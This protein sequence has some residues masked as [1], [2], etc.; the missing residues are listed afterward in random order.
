VVPEEELSVED[1]ERLVK[2]LKKYDSEKKYSKEMDKELEG[3]ALKLLSLGEAAVPGLIEV[4]EDDEGLGVL[5]AMEA[6]GKI[7]DERAIAPLVD[8][9]ENPD[10]G[11]SAADSLLGFGPACV[12]EVIR[13][14]EHLIACPVEDKG[15]F[16][17]LTTYHLRTIGD[18]RCDRSIEFLNGLLDDYMSK[19]PRETFDPSKLDWKY[20]NVDFFQILDAMVKQ[21]DERAIPHIENAR[22][23]FPPEYVE[24]RICQVAIDRIRSGEK[25]G[26]LPMEAIEMAVPTEAIM[27]AFMAARNWGDSPD[28]TVGESSEEEWQA[29]NAEDYEDVYQFK[30][31][32]RGARPPIWRRIQVPG[33]YTFWDLHSAIQDAMGWDDCHMHAFEILDPSVGA[34]VVIGVPSG[35]PNGWGEDLPGWKIAVAEY[36]SPEN[37]EAKYEYDFGDSWEHRVKLEKILPREENLEYPRCIDGKRACPP[38]DCGGISGYIDLLEIVNDP[39]HEEHEEMLEWVGEDFDPEDFSPDEV[40]FGD[41]LQRLKF[42]M[43]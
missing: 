29:E 37:S 7:G 17:L 2:E 6:L 9:L 24:Y 5:H 19:M 10:I 38:E 26:Y 11:S 41:P 1:I 4:L 28:D 13:N 16:I 25:E 23:A 21:Q 18:I 36:F 8:L 20:R 35:D 32:L 12:P 33:S 22:D 40:F 3:I 43:I 27:D 34:V 31:S 42:R 14:M 30:V 39:Q 15:G